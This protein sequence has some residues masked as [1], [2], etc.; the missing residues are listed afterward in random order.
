[1]LRYDGVEVLDVA[2]RHHAGRGEPGEQTLG[3]ALVFVRRGCF[4]RNT[5]GMEA[6]LDPTVAYCMT[7][8]RSSATTIHTTAATTA[9]LCSLTPA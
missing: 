3:H 1:V 7:R 2:C 9:Q 4:A 5:D 8:V 6:L